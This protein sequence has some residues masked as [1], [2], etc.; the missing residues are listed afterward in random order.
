MLQVP[1]VAVFPLPVLVHDRVHAVLP[2]GATSVQVAAPSDTWAV[3]VNVPKRPNT[4][5]AMATAAMSVIAMRITVAR[6]GEMAFLFA[7][8]CMFI[9]PGCLQDNINNYVLPDYISNKFF[10]N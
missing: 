3:F 5:P 9:R 4:N 6:T 1:E 7:V 10:G 8:V 2:A